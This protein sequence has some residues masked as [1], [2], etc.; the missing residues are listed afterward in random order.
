MNSKISGNFKKFGN[1]RGDLIIFY[2]VM[3]FLFIFILDLFQQG[4]FK[5]TIQKEIHQESFEKENELK[6]TEVCVGDE[7]G[8]PSQLF[9][10]TFN[11]RNTL[12]ESPAELET[13]VSFES[14]GTE[15]TP[16]NLTFIILDENENE[17]YK[18]KTSL[19]VETEEIIIWDYAGLSKLSSGNYVAVL[20][21]LYNTNVFDEFK[22]E[23]KVSNKLSIFI[24]K[25]PYLFLFF[26]GIII[27]Y[28]IN[29]IIKIWKNKLNYLKNEINLEDRK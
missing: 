1:F 20:Q 27:L 12:L 13:I 6:K 11:L 5:N 22:Q 18:E 7:C 14:F 19:I 3:F 29:F 21:T 28:L 24:E 10:I 15:P 16:V 9:D 23:F 17:I 25:H 8:I 26:I 4:F 2:L